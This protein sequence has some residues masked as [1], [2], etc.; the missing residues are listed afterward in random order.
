MAEPHGRDHIGRGVSVHHVCI[1]R[2]RQLAAQQAVAAP[3][4]KHS[5]LAGRAVPATAELHQ[6]VLAGYSSNTCIIRPCAGMCMELLPLLLKHQCNLFWN[7]WK[8]YK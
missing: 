6:T 8:C 2:D 3:R 4:V 5:E 7:E 1:P